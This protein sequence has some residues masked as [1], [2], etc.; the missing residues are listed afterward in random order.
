MIPAEQLAK[1]FQSN[2]RLTLSLLDG[3]SHLESLLTPSFVANCA[4]WILGHLIDGR[5]EAL[6]YMGKPG[7]WD[8]ETVARYKSGSDSITSE[9][10]LSFGQ[11]IADFEKAQFGLELALAETSP[12]FLSEIVAT[13]FGDIPRWQ[14]I[15]G[16]GWHET[17]HIGQFELLKAVILAER[18][19]KHSE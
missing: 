1:T 16:L 17:Y 12:E 15:S 18:D 3:I 9:T 6:K 4:N 19:A 13:S 8:E 10:A 11:L 2:F 14:H 5:N 7:F